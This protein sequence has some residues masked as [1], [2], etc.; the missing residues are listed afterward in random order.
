MVDANTPIGLYS[1]GARDLG[2]PD[3]MTWAADASIPFVQLR[4]GARGHAV[5]ERPL[6]ELERWRE[7]TQ[8]TCPITLVTSDATLGELTG[9]DPNP[10]A[11][12]Q[13]VLDLTC[14][15]AAV[16]GARRVRILADMPAEA[17][18]HSIHPPGLDISLVIELHHTSWWT[19][20]GLNTVA[21]L[22]CGEPGIRLLA[23]SAQAAAGLAPHEPH[24]ARQLATR[25]IALSDVLHLS[26]DGSGLDAHGHALLVEAARDADVNLEIGF[27]WTGEPRTAEACLRRYHAACAWW[28]S[29]WATRRKDE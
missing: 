16:L 8:S 6:R 19:E 12:A 17:T 28:R 18:K 11:A 15:A 7:V 27:E 3:L 23:D 2:M 29:L 10:R 25:V 20:T 24:E 22:V 14:E 5:L 21:A 1:I 9:A 13:R 4:G 26:D